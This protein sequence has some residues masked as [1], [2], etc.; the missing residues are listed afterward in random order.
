MYLHGPMKP[1][2]DTEIAKHTIPLIPGMKPVKQKLRRM[3][4]DVTLK[5]K[6]EVS[7]QL[8]AG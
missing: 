4:P 8:D 6:E 7:K 1:G 3:K 5:I 2:I